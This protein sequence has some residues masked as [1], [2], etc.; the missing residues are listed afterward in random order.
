[1]ANVQRRTRA[2]LP[3]LLLTDAHSQNPLK[4]RRT[5]CYYVC[6]IKQYVY[7]KGCGIYFSLSLLSDCPATVCVCSSVL[8]T[9]WNLTELYK[10]LSVLFRTFCR[11]TLVSN[12]Q[13]GETPHRM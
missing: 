9:K 11:G 5:E 4:K 6:A 13:L 10:R 8:T 2:V 3:E 1:M 12:S 7:C